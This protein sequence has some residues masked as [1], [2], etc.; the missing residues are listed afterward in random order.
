MWS[1]SERRLVFQSGA[2]GSLAAVRR[3]RA[4]LF[5]LDGTLVDS[6][7]AI[8]EAL[9]AALGEMG[10]P[11]KSLEEVRGLVGGGV[12]AVMRRAAGEDHEA[13]GVRR[14][15]VHYEKIF[16]DKTR[17]LPG[18]GESIE[19]LHERGYLLGVGTNKPSDFSRRLVHHFGWGDRIPAVVG[20]D[21][22]ERPK[23]A[24]DILLSLCEALRLRPAEAIYVGDMPLDAVTARSAGMPA[25]LVPTGSASLE[26]IRRAEPER[27]LASLWE[28]LR[29]LP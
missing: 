20:P 25:W 23:P 10:M 17:L 12:H 5:D 13:E 6:Y 9:N 22:V 24:P 4:V 7:E 21:D 14:F 2:C 26:E 11:P 15:R 19:A 28:T 27:I 16:L 8:A 1:G 18:A 3:V 29:A